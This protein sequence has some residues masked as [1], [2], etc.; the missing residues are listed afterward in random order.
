MKI[1]KRLR[2]GGHI[3]D[4]IYPHTFIERSDA[5]GIAS[6]LDN[7]ILIGTMNESGIPYP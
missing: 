2:I 7:K 6:V 1:P 5:R 3:I 4:V